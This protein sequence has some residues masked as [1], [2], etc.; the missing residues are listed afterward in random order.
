MYST[1]SEISITFP[2]MEIYDIED[3]DL[4]ADVPVQSRL[5]LTAWDVEQWES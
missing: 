2:D 1:D 5:T 3:S 4:E